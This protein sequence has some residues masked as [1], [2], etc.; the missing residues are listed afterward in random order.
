MIKYFTTRMD[1]ETVMLSVKLPAVVCTLLAA[2]FVAKLAS[3]I[4]HIPSSGSEVIEHL[5]RKSDATQREFQRLR[6][7]LA[8]EPGNLD[9]AAQLAQRYIDEARASGDP[10]YLGYAEAALSPWWK[11][12]QPPVKVL[13]LR[14]TLLQST[15]QFP[16]ALRDLNAVLKDDR[17]NAQAWLTRATILQVQGE[18]MPARTSCEH[19]YSLAPALITTTCLS[20][21]ASLNGSAAQSLFELQSALQKETNADPNVKVWVL[22][23]MAEISKRRGV[24]ADAEKYFLEAMRVA[25]PDSYLLGAYSDFLLEQN[26]PAE[27]IKLLADKKRVDG[28][29]LRYALALQATG[30]PRAKQETQSL[31]ERFAAA[32]MRGDTIH[33]REHSRFALQLQHDPKEAL[34][35]AKLDWAVQK[36][37]A[38]I[39]AYLEAASAAKDPAAAIPVLQWLNKNGLE[40]VSLSPLIASLNG[41]K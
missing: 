23:L 22:T 34:R 38:D 4:P 1:R 31:A 5:P 40:D 3:A 13:V 12:A 20:N 11:L 36:E 27:V 30:D 24:S 32:A 16:D 7:A 10:R 35:I 33:L 39:R 28:L 21:V 6:V 19:L 9:L 41:A 25:P 29:L 37:P 8:K 18:L 14:A 15:H 17:N 26:R 2:L